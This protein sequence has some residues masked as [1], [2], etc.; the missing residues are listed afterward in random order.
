[1]IVGADLLRG[2]VQAVGAT[3]LLTGSASIAALAL[4]QA[5]FGMADAF[6]RP[7]RTGLVLDAVQPARLQDAARPAE[8]ARVREQLD[9]D[10]VRRLERLAAA[11][12]ATPYMALLASF[13]YAL[14]RHGACADV[15]IGIPVANRELPECESIVGPFVNTLRDAAP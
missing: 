6:S 8:G 15:V 7:A 4:L 2:S 1:M 5:A 13:G 14:G 3:L 10:A 9:T 11:E 12:S